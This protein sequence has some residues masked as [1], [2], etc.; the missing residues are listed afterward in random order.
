MSARCSPAC[1]PV[2]HAG[3]LTC[4]ACGA[5][6]WP[7]EAEWLDNDTLVATYE[8]SCSHAHEP[9]TLV[10]GGEVTG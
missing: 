8:P 9:V 5:P 2:H 7:T 3:Y 4:P 1:N 6:G 10:V